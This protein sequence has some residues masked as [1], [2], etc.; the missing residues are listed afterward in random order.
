MTKIKEE[1]LKVA[2]KKA[3]APIKPSADFSAESLQARREWDNT[4]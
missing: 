3:T 1:M 4:F 2:S